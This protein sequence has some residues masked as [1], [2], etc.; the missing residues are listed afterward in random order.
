MTNSLI[1]QQIRANDIQ[2]K[3]LAELSD[4]SYRA[5]NGDRQPA[6]GFANNVTALGK[7][8]FEDNQPIDS[9]T[10]EMIKEY[11]EEQSKPSGLKDAF[12]EDLKYFPT[13]EDYTL[14]PFT[15]IPMSGSSRPATEADLTGFQDFFQ[16]KA[17]E[18]Q[19]I[20]LE[21]QD[22]ENEL[23]DVKALIEKEADPYELNLLR[24]HRDFLKNRISSLKRKKTRCETDVE[25]ILSEIELIKAN[26]EENRAKQA[27]INTINKQGIKNVEQALMMA[28]RNK[29]Y[30]EQ[31]IDEE[32]A[33]YLTR[34]KDI[35]TEKFDT[36]LYKDKAELA[37]IKKFKLNLKELIRRDDIIEEVVKFFAPNVIFK[38][39]KIF[40]KIKKE[41]LEKYGYDNKSV[42]PDDITDFIDEELNP[43]PPPIYGATAPSFPSTPVL[44]ATPLT[45]RKPTGTLTPPIGT[46]NIA[47]FNDGSVSTIEWGIFDNALYLHNVDTGKHIYMKIGTIYDPKAKRDRKCVFYT[48]TDN[49]KTQF[50]EIKGNNFRKY[51]INQLNM[52]PETKLLIFR[53][54]EKLEEV[55]NLL[56]SYKLSPVPA[57]EIEKRSG[58]MFGFSE[59][60]FGWGMHS[61]EKEIPKTSKFGNCIILTH[62]LFYKNILS[63]KDKSLHSIEG[64]KNAKV[65]NKFVE[66]IMNILNGKDIPKNV[67]NSLNSSEKEL[68]NQIIHLSGLN[69]H[70][71]HNGSE[72]IINELK[73]RMELLEGE[74]QAGN[75]NKE[76]VNEL[77][78]ILMKL[79]HYGVISLVAAKKYLKQF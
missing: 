62:K 49:K 68:Y 24:K 67:I 10:K 11:Q 58:G 75:N 51:I 13:S 29:L 44:T 21:I 16:K 39:N 14:V 48:Y 27:E 63:L 78:E 38:I 25:H 34:L 41:F 72:E 8:P 18:L 74:I 6:R 66:I 3:L 65:S 46:K 35:Q 61:H 37:N 30:V 7:I 9:I 36:V 76:L 40:P 20:R 56:L 52:D 2:R 64:L 70:L 5:F 22:F 12:G 59:E 43:P 19:D 32:D 15:P 47:Q 33:D 73:H 71:H 55:Y 26:I 60:Y 54:V 57:S 31:G 23:F 69:K 50:D 4:I 79:Y 77:R 1:E 45:G 28:N 42:R 53:T 17:E